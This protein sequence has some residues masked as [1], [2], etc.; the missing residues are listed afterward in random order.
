MPWNGNVI[1]L[2]GPIVAAVWGVSYARH[3]RESR[4][5]QMKIEQYNRAVFEHHMA[6]R[7]DWEASRP[8]TS[9]TMSPEPLAAA[10][11]TMAAAKALTFFGVVTDTRCIVGGTVE[12]SVVVVGPTGA[13]K[14]TGILNPSVL[15]APGAVLVVTS[16]AQDAVATMGARMARGR[17]WLY[18]PTHTVAERLLPAG[19]QRVF[20]DPLFDCQHYDRAKLVA[21]HLVSSSPGTNGTEGNAVFFATLAKNLLAGLTFAAANHPDLNVGDLYDW[22]EDQDLD[23]ARAVVFAMASDPSHPRS[24]EASK[25]LTKLDSVGRH[26]A[27]MRDSIFTTAQVALDAYD[28]ESVRNYVGRHNFAIEDFVDSCDTVYVCA[29]AEYQRAVAPVLTL[30]VEEV[31][32]LR[33]AATTEAHRRGQTVVPMLAAFDEAAHIASLPQMPRFLAEGRGNGFLTLMLLQTLGQAREL[34]GE[35]GKTI[36]DAAALKVAFG[37]IAD[38]ETLAQLSVLAGDWDREYHSTSESWSAST[39]EGTSTSQSWSPLPTPTRGTSSGTSESV[40]FGRSTN[41]HKERRISDGDIATIA[42]GY[43]LVLGGGEP[44]RP[45]ELVYSYLA[46]WQAVIAAAEARALHLGPVYEIASPALAHDLDPLGALFDR[47]ADY[48]A[49]Q[50]APRE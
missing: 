36:F 3:G 2:L 29:P 48:L 28:F 18:D 13:G 16:K 14:T 37:G 23:P 44:A 40:T 8:M 19:V 12:Q 17:V 35:K 22:V 11:S 30:F 38:S 4:I 43:A 49:A 5:H 42:R 39:N 24:G 7:K 50:P 33:A 10:S 47:Y 41:S 34:W 31:Y 27:K 9:L 45:V 25:V 6:T 46:P 1:F 15:M 20:W 26:E 21:D 32:R